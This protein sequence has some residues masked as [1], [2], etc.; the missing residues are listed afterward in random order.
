MAPPDN[1]DTAFGGERGVWAM[2]LQLND[3]LAE[4]PI[5]TWIEEV[6][7]ADAEDRTEPMRGLEAVDHGSGRWVGSWSMG[8]WGGTWRRWDNPSPTRP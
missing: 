7:A 4:P 1:G 6:E 3:P 2:T 5:P 8:F